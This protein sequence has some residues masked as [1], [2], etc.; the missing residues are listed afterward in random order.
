MTHK[1]LPKHTDP[2]WSILSNNKYNPENSYKTRPLTRISTR[3]FTVI[4]F[5]EIST[6]KEH[7]KSTQGAP[8]AHCSQ[9]V[10]IVQKIQSRPT[11]T[12]AGV[13]VIK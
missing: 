12:K 9:L 2:N 8:F 11:H 13:L 4:Q 1:I 7:H 5:Y 3:D 10:D 6:P